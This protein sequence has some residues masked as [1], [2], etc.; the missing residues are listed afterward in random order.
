MDNHLSTVFFR[1]QPPESS[2][3]ESLLPGHH[4]MPEHRKQ[5]EEDLWFAKSGYRV[6]EMPTGQ[7]LLIN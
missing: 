4:A 6:L 1:V 3:Q 5:L 2:I 7:G